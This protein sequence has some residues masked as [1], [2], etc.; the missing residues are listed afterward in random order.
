MRR[1]F[2]LLLSAAMLLSLCLSAS[3]AEVHPATIDQ[4]RT[5]SL[6]VYKYDLTAA[7][8]DGLTDS[9]YLS[10]GQENPEA[11]AAFAP[12]KFTVLF[13]DNID[14]TDTSKMLWKVFNNVDPSRDIV[15]IGKGIFIDACKKTPADGHTRPWP[16]EL[17]H[18]H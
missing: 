10:T 4:S 7:E 17:S 3:A 15:K 13:D 16:D 2:S 9:V 5:G 11:A 18:E 8:S 14:I 12:R 1:F 6:T